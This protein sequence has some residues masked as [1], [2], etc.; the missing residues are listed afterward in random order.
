MALEIKV[1]FNQNHWVSIS[2]NYKFIISKSRNLINNHNI[3]SLENEKKNR[4]E[5]VE[6]F[7]MDKLRRT[8]DLNAL[9]LELKICHTF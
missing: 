5:R 4:E 9:L 3:S 8:K 1:F 6:V 2:H 7:S